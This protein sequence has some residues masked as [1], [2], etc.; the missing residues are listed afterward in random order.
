M[1]SSRPTRAPRWFT[2]LAIV[3]GVLVILMF[4]I[5]HVTGALGPGVH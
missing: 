4:L 1:T 3:I 5:L 2:V